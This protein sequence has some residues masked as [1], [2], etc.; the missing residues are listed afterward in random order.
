MKN[1]II[2]FR[3]LFLNYI[4]GGEGKSEIVEIN[5]NSNFSEL[6]KKSSTNFDLIIR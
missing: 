3:I 2:K 1:K 5:Q 4:T 6:L